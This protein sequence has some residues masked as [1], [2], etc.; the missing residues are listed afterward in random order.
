MDER[1]RERDQSLSAE[2]TG[3]KMAAWLGQMGSL[4]Y[5]VFYWLLTLELLINYGAPCP[6][7]CTCTL[8]TTDCSRLDMTDVPQD[9]PKSTVHL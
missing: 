6:Q 5:H 3:Y 8:D 4:S 1:E 7:N 9:L 2:T